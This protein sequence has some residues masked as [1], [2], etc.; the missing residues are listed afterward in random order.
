MKA[1]SPQ[2]ARTFAY[3]KG[4]SGWVTAD[5]MAQASGA[6]SHTGR[7]YAR[8]LKEAGLLECRETY[9]GFRYRVT[10]P[11]TEAGR[12]LQRRLEEAAEIHSVA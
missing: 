12:D 4:A 6:A 2:L 7:V 1:I 10:A 8:K 5:E 11:A 9:P 3:L